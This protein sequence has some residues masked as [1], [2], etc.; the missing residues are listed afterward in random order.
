MFLLFF[1]KRL[2]TRVS[3]RELVVHLW[4]GMLILYSV[5]CLLKANCQ[6]PTS[7][8]KWSKFEF[9]SNRSE[10]LNIGSSRQKKCWLSL[11]FFD[12]FFH[13]N[14][15][16]F[17]HYFWCNVLGSSFL[18]LSFFL[19]NKI[20]CYKKKF[21]SIHAIGCDSLILLN[22]SL[23]TSWFRAMMNLTRINLLVGEASKRFP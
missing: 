3:K 11:S 22:V 15:V 6:M 4:P 12:F 5:G 9:L 19:W 13:L 8:H 14:C 1:L 16:L 7:D 2:C 20:Y 17:L 21:G 10:M 18:Y 23:L